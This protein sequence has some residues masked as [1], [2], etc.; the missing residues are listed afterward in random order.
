MPDPAERPT[1]PPELVCFDLGGVVVRICR[2]WQEGCE[3]A[4]VT[5]ADG[6]HELLAGDAWQAL[7]ARY[8]AGELAFDDFVRAAGR[9]AEGRHAE[10]D[11]RRIHEAWILGEY[12]G[13]TDLLRDLAARGIPTAMLSNTCERHL[14]LMRDLPALRTFHR[15]FAS[16]KLGLVKPDPRIYDHVAREL[17]VAPERIVFFDDTPA[18]VEAAR[19]RGWTAHDVDPHDDP[20]GFV[21]RT[22]RAAGLRV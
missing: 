16:P 6:M 19:A 15:V 14:E 18:N 10:D 7:N 4:G 9:L 20:P 3:R 2:T 1:P 5:P 17:G 13:A 21:R 8:Q 22:L 12:D 11:V